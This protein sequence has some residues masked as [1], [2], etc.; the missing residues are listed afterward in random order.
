MEEEGRIRRFTSLNEAN[1]WRIHTHTNKKGTIKGDI[2][3]DNSEDVQA[4]IYEDAQ[5]SE[6][7]VD[8]VVGLPHRDQKK[9]V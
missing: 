6:E 2:S 1:L 4:A 8:E 9:K 7:E 3:D 5:E